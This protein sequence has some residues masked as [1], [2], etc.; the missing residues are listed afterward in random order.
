MIPTYTRF[1]LLPLFG[2]FLLTA[3]G[4]APLHSQTPVLAF[5]G[6]SSIP[7][8]FYVLD[9]SNLSVVQQT[10]TITAL[11]G[12]VLGTIVGATYDFDANEVYILASTGGAT[13]KTNRKVFRV[14]TAT[15]NATFVVDPVNDRWQDIAYIG[16]GRFL[17][18]GGQQTSGFS[19]DIVELDTASGGVSVVNAISNAST[20]HSLAWNADEDKVYY[21]TGGTFSSADFLRAYDTTNWTFTSPTL[22]G[23]AGNM[24]GIAYLGN[25]TLLAVDYTSS[26]N[27]LL[28]PTAG[29]AVQTQLNPTVGVNSN[30]KIAAIAS[31]YTPPVCDPIPTDAPITSGGANFCP[32]DSVLLSV[33]AYDD[34]DSVEWFLNGNAISSLGKD[35]SIFVNQAGNYTY[36]ITNICGETGLTSNFITLNAL[37]LP[38]VTITTDGDSLLCSTTDSELLTGASGGT[39]Q[40]YRNGLPIA[41]ANS[42]TLSISEP[43][44][45]NQLKTNMN[46]CSDS[47]AVGLAVAAIDDPTSFPN[48]GDVCAGSG[49]ITLNAT[50]AGGTY[51]SNGVILD[52]PVDPD[53]L[54]LGLIT[55]VYDTLSCGY[56]NTVTFNI[57][58]PQVFDFTLTDTLINLTT[59]D[60]TITA[61]VINPDPAYT[62]NWFVDQTFL[63]GTGPTVSFD[64]TDPGEYTIQVFADINGCSSTSDSTV[65]VI[66]AVGRNEQLIG[67]LDIYPNPVQDELTITHGPSL[68]LQRIALL[69]LDGRSLLELKANV[70]TAHRV[71]VGALPTGVYV[72]RLETDHGLVHQRIIKH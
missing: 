56:E 67:A 70:G 16:N 26:F 14:D 28:V 71:S 33:P 10:K 36:E 39:L 55:Y 3:M 35:S 34:I 40:W 66:N 69:S 31:M 12:D 11:N 37:N 54:L 57:I 61:S 32:N 19:D 63:S 65:T 51:F 59:G 8:Q 68:Q 62:Y 52:N 60:S 17:L 9:A 47:A 42:N 58:E 1:S 49:P 48:P 5:E 64:F 45:Y 25:D 22:S 53:T 29:G 72:L 44:V 6:S 7:A 30:S 38:G 46:G 2:L 18:T 41:G 4:T 15:G 13:A 50:P 23:G 43:G 27:L 21:A 20:V 24:T